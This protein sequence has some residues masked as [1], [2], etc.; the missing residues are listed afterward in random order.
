M[1]RDSLNVFENSNSGNVAGL[2]V[3]LAENLFNRGKPRK[4][5]VSF[6]S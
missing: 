4:T 6:R 5:D 2:L 3:T 1:R